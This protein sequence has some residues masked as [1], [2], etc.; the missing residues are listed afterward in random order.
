MT[1]RGK[2]SVEGQQKRDV[3]RFI[4]SLNFNDRELCE[5]IFTATKEQL[6][7]LLINKYDYIEPEALQLFNYLTRR[8]DLG[9]VLT[10]SRGTG[11]EQQVPAPEEPTFYT[12]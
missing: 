5:K 7:A 6:A 4:H 10:D 11:T 9:D 2:R 3:H 12:F 8:N 1:H